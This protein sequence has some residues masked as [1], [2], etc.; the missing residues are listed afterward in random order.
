MPFDL[1]TGESRTCW[2]RLLA[3]RGAAEFPEQPYLDS[4]VR[5]EAFRLGEITRPSAP[6]AMIDIGYLVCSRSIAGVRATVFKPFVGGFRAIR[7]QLHLTTQGGRFG[8]RVGQR[9]PNPFT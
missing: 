9:F 6:L 1:A 4:A 2:Q 7:R 8:R 5:G 3:C